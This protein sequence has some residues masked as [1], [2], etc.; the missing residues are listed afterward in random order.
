MGTATLQALFPETRRTLLVGFFRDPDRRFYLREIVRLANKGQ[1]GVQRELANLVQAG[2]L[3]RIDEHGR[4]YYGANR[5]SPI[6]AE[7]HALI[8]KTAGAPVVLGRAL[9]PLKSITVALIFGSVA[10]GD[11]R[12]DSDIDVAVVGDVSF[13]AVTAALRDAQHQLA[14]EVN[15]VVLTVRELRSR[16]VRGDPFIREMLG[17]AKTYLI[18]TEHDL[19]TVVGESLAG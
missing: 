10:R 19:E 15:P 8:T 4:S 12:A 3:I 7:I 1:G 16:W 14:R 11:E 17:G 5:S 9:A 2:V 18:G 6:F 13:R